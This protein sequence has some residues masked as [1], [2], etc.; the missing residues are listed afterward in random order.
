MLLMKIIGV[1]CEDHVQQN[2][3]F[4]QRAE[5]WAVKGS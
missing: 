3:D 2:K 4:G 5:L 1:Y